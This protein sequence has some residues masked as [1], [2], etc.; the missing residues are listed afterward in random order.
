MQKN[1]PNITLSSYDDIFSTDHD[2]SSNEQIVRQIPLSDLHPFRD[3][4]FGVRDD[5]E[6]DKMVESINSYGV[7]TP[8]IARPRKE[9]GYEI[10]AGHRRCHASEKAGL[11]TIPVIVR[12]L[13]DDAAT[14][15]MVDS[16]LQREDI[17]PSE[18]AKA[19]K[20]KMDAMKHQ[21]SREDLKKA[22]KDDLSQ[23]D[24]GD[25]TCGQVD[26]K[27]INSKSRDVIAEEAGESGKQVQ[28]F[29][30]LTNLTPDL[31]QMV[32]DHK[33]AFNPAVEI[34]YLKP[35]DQ[36]LLIGAMEYAQAT[37]SLSQAQ[38]LKKFSQQGMLKY[39]VMCAVM[40]EEKK[41]AV[42]R[43]TI[44]GDV[45]KKYFPKSYSP[46][47]MENTIIKLLEQ[48]QNKREHGEQSI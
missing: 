16:N 5:E 6:M 8:A 30:R 31:M 26:H 18:K 39:E 35:E 19:F 2:G 7:L 47:E 48:W 20:M 40:T 42:S 45:L 3:H 22:N 43:I 12:N 15:L 10:I 38:R 41:P 44:E 34:S 36:K 46:K 25:L 23:S 4:P 33:L 14:I 28:R 1:K 24:N 9:G 32:D 27:V 21:G 37:P 11:E 29:I 13:D 17:L